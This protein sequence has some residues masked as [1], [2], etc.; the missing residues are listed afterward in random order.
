MELFAAWS[1]FIDVIFE[2]RAREF[3]I[4]GIERLP[5]C[6]FFKRLTHGTATKPRP[7]KRARTESAT[8][9]GFA[10]DEARAIR[11]DGF[12][13]TV[14]AALAKSAES[15]GKNPADREF[16]IQQI[17]DR[18]VVSTEIV[19]ILAAAGDHDAGHFNSFGR[20]SR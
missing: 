7:K 3:P 1:I 9:T 11:D 8:R 10:S 20:I 2:V 6:Q 17:L 18:A 14:R 13:Q 19:D 5:F 4:V 15:S 12:F 16:A